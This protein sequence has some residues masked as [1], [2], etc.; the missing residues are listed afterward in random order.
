LLVAERLHPFLDQCS[1]SGTL[2][3]A[4]ASRGWKVFLDSD[5]DIQRAVAYVQDNP[6]K[7]GLP[8]QSWDFVTENPAHVG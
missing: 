4:W 8:R 7:Q 3:P 2:P 6:V 1:A 5:A